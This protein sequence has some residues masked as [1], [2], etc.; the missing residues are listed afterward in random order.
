MP[1]R[2]IDRRSPASI[3]I[4]IVDDNRDNRE[5]YAHYLEFCG[6]EVRTAET[7]LDAIHQAPT[8]KPNVIIMDLSMP[9]MDGWRA[10]R[11]LKAEKTTA[12]IP[13]VA[14]T[15]HAFTGAAAKAK[16]A[17]CDVYLSKPCLPD[18]LLKEIRR[19]LPTA[20]VLRPRGGARRVGRSAP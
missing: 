18:E 19:V 2:R 4:L 5:L 14:V 8:F 11:W 3:R 7:G 6:A 10:S 15:G 13:I 9:A 16:Q 20:R 17:G 1:G 12:H